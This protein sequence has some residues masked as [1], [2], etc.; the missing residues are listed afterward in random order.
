[1]M[2]K[3][4]MLLLLICLTYLNVSFSQESCDCKKFKTGKFQTVLLDS[5]TIIV[6]KRKYQ[7]EFFDGEVFKDKIIWLDDCV[8]KL[9][10]INSSVS[11]DVSREVL[12]CEIVKTEDHSYTVKY[13]FE[14]GNYPP[15]EIVIYEL[16]YI[17]FGK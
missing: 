5:E 9:L 7:K 2:K 11:S 10:P 13:I 6:R 8:Y 16:G 4:H 1:M 14:S 3:K 17:G 15:S 12:I